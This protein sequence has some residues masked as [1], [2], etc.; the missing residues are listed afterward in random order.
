MSEAF[1]RETKEQIK[2]IWEAINK[3]Y[4][5]KQPTEIEDVDGLDEL[6]HYVAHRF[7]MA[8]NHRQILESKHRDLKDRVMAAEERIDS[9]KPT[10]Y[11][12]RLDEIESK[13]RVYVPMAERLNTAVMVIEELKGK[14]QPP[15]EPAD[16]KDN[17]IER[18]SAIVDDL[19]S[20]LF[21]LK[22]V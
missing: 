1:E 8:H 3:L 21:Q 5:G 11:D 16:T 15:E 18:L 4:S 12:S 2:D 13:M 10:D 9:L 20:V 6:K 22:S 7:T 17:T 19:D 14:I